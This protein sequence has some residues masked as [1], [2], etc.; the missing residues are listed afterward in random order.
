MAASCGHIG[1]SPNMKSRRAGGERA[2]V[3]R[4]T[5]RRARRLGKALLEDAPRRATRGWAD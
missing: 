4:Q 2:F 1:N 5:A 3:K